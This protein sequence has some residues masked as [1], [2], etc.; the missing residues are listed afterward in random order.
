MVPVM[1]VEPAS[2]AGQRSEPGPGGNSVAV[3]TLFPVNSPISPTT[4]GL[5][6]HV[7]NRY[8]PVTGTVHLY[9]IDAPPRLSWMVCS[10]GSTV[11]PTLVPVTDPEVPLIIFALAKLSLAGGRPEG[12]CG[13]ILLVG[14][15]GWLVPPAALVAVTVKE[16]LVPSVRPVTRIGQDDPV[17]VMPPGLEV[18]V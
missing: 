12:A 7:S 6:V 1:M 9:H 16:Y 14:F 5:A 11:A 15:E 18:T 17:A 2:P 13:V 8:D 4:P 3:L 10:P